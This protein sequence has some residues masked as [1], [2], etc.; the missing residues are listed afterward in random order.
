MT[1]LLSSTDLAIAVAVAADD[2]R[3]VA[4]PSR[5]GGFAYALEDAVGVIE[6]HSSQGEADA[7]VASIREAVS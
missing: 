2:L 4:R 6:V 3:I 1:L 5:F 7:R